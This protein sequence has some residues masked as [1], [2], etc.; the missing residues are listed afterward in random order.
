M[1]E[2]QKIDDQL[3]LNPWTE[4]GL[5]TIRGCFAKDLTT[6]EFKVFFGLGKSLGAN[7]FTREIWAIK[8]GNSP[9][10][11]FLGRDFYRKKAQEQQDYDGHIVN[12][13][14][15][16]DG[17]TIENGEP[18]HIVKSFKGRG[19]LVGAFC[20]VYRKA[21]KVPY[22]VSVDLKEYNTG[23]SNWAKMPETMIKKVAEAQALRGAYQG[24]FK[25]TYDESEQSTIE[26]SA[27]ELPTVEQKDYAYSLLNSSNYNDEEKVSIDDELS[28]N[29]L[30]MDR[31]NEI[32][33]NLKMN[34]SESPNPSMKEIQKQIDKKM[35]LDRD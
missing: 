19:N 24:V 14:Y 1:K 10:A 34:Q 21:T 13:I 35:S 4:R 11:I 8:Y 23:K 31:F 12:A 9:A 18:K 30:S 25:G 33:N 29:S 6:D 7:P 27:E 26:A 5:E 3:H 2:L 16:E 17:F 32:V 28:D 15:E 22:F 20:S